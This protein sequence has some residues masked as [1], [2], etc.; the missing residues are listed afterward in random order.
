M[1]VEIFDRTCQPVRPTRCG[2]KIIAQAYHVIDAA[3]QVRA[4]VAEARDSL[5]G[6]FRIGIL[7]TIAPY[8]LPRFFPQLSAE[9][10]D[11][12]LRIVEMK[13]REIERALSL[14]AL[15][16]AILVRTDGMEQFNVMTLFYEQF[17]AYVARGD[18]LFERTTIRTADLQNKFL[19]LLDEGH[20]F[21]EQML[22]FCELQSAANSKT[23][24]TLG[25]IETFM[26]MV[27]NGK[28]ITFI[29]ELALLQ[30]SDL[31][32]QLVRPFAIP[33]P[34]REIVM[35]TSQTFV[36]KSILQLLIDSIRAS[37]PPEMLQMNN[38]EQRV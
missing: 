7:P 19:W 4:I 22:K 37:V 9:H 38:T 20:C 3:A 14:G 8:L 35:L 24:Y 17:L 5:A 26:R 18:S 31:Q 23:T 34:V 25:S 1:G 13:T 12:D 32:R 2:E 21:R 11:I 6:T 10:P 33:I 36:R 30:L 27:E 29:P 16:A 15:D 28:G